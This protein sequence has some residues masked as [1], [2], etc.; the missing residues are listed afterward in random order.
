MSEANERPQK[1]AESA[2]DVLSALDF[3]PQCASRSCARD[4]WVW[5]CCDKCGEVQIVCQ[6]H[7]DAIRGRL[8]VTHTSCG[9]S[10]P[11]SAVFTIG[12]L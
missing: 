3:T 5:M 12:H 4:A 7:S 11:P 10:G 2:V 1:K 6:F 9:T 8:T